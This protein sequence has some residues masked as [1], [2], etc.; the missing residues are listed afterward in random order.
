VRD[1]GLKVMTGGGEE[2]VDEE[3]KRGEMGT[4]GIRGCQE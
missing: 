1:G 3:E 4:T 2:E